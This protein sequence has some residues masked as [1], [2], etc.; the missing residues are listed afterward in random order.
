MKKKRKKPTERRR[1]SPSL[2]EIP[3][4]ELVE[5]DGELRS[6]REQY[7]DVPAEERRRAAQWAH[8]S[9]HAAMLFAQATGT[10]DMVHPAWHDAAAPLAIDPSFA[11]A[12]LTV[13]SL[14]YQYGRADEALRV[15]LELTTLPADTEDLV[16]IIDKAGDFLIDQEDTGRA[17]RF[18]AAA[19]RAYPEVAVYRVGLGYC[20][21]Q[22]GR[23]DESIAWHQQAVELE[24]DNYLHLNDW[25]YSLLQAG[26]LDEAEQVLQR[27]VKLAPP[28]YK[29]AKG[30]LAHLRKIR[31]ERSG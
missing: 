14:E 26:R 1:K 28:H 13:G 15:F 6:L 23:L 25:G 3:F 19:V 24:P 29:L 30:N 17:E 11:P 5:L 4:R 2:A 10:T 22:A 8:D 9:A 7:V 27:A 16:E 21:A 31:S 12:M 20:L 18:Y